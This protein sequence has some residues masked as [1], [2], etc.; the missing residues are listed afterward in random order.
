MWIPVPLTRVAAWSKRTLAFARRIGTLEARVAAL[1]EAL[2]KQPPDA[3]PFCGERA[4]RKTFAGPA[5][6][7]AKSASRLDRWKCEKCGK[8][9]PRMVYFLAPDR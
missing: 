7:D 1:E 6:G 2:T 8:E 5:I 4:M 3:C 9:E